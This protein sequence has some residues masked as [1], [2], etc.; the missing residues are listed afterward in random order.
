M[1][2]MEYL[3]FGN[4]RILSLI[5]KKNERFISILDIE[6][7]I[8]YH[9]RQ[10]F[11]ENKKSSL[12]YINPSTDNVNSVFFNSKRPHLFISFKELRNHVKN[13]RFTKNKSIYNWVDSID[14]NNE[15][16]REENCDKDEESNVSTKK[17]EV[18]D[19][20]SKSEI[21]RNNN[22]K[23]LKLF[24]F[25]SEEIRVVDENGE[26]WFVAKDICDILGLT[27]IT[28]AVNGLDDEDKKNITIHY[29]SRG[30]PTLTVINEPGLYQLIFNSRKDKARQFKKWVINQVLP[31]IR[32]T[33]KFTLDKDKAPDIV[34][35][36]FSEIESIKNELNE[37]L[38]KI[39]NIISIDEYIPRR[40]VPEKIEH[41]VMIGTVNQLSNNIYDKLNEMI[42]LDLRIWRRIW[43]EINYFVTGYENVQLK[44]RRKVPENEENGVFKLMTEDELKYLTHLLEYILRSLDNPGESINKDN[45][46]RITEQLCI[47]FNSEKGVNNASG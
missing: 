32:Q 17:P 39:N 12:L 24:S 6:K 11:L 46:V 28:M 22:D 20:N 30:N 21:K 31:Q 33:G 14:N 15:N 8:K 4:E 23:N 47:K 40:E 38:D 45:I 34:N 16:S 26:P 10:V 36:L 3:S 41:N 7:V 37:K 27:N 29:K 43:N 1:F 42:D 18:I 2:D 35:S 5:D 19:N 9:C 13:S 25:N 44:S